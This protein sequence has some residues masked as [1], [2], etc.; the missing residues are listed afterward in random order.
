MVTMDDLL[1]EIVKGEVNTPDDLSNYIWL[2]YIN[3]QSREKYT[4][5][6]LAPD[7]E[8]YQVAYELAKCEDVLKPDI[9]Y[10]QLEKIKVSR[11]ELLNEY[12]PMIMK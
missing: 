5:V 10:E 8:K 6:G 11:D 9:K 2:F 1:K 7:I 12:S 3:K 4:I